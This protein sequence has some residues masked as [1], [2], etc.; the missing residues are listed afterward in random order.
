MKEDNKTK[1]MKM[2]STQ[3]KVMKSKPL[4]S[5]GKFYNT[6]AGYDLFYKGSKIDKWEAYALGYKDARRILTDK[7]QV[8]AEKR[9]ETELVD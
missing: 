5:R 9:K 7:S 2:T 3:F 1:V 8:T 6:L 4:T